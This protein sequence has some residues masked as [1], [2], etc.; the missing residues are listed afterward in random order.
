[1]L[2]KMCLLIFSATPKVIEDLKRSVSQLKLPKE[3][4]PRL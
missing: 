3:H 2:K 1:M 4:T